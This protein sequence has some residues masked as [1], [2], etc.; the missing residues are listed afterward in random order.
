M[1]S[2]TI[3][4]RD[5]AFKISFKSIQT[6]YHLFK[7][8]FLSYDKYCDLLYVSL[9]KIHQYMVSLLLFLAL[10]PNFHF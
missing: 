5:V 6:S 2:D 9:P 1:L 8:L 10:A 3:T 4:L 7:L